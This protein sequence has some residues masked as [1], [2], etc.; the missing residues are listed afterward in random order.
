[1]FFVCQYFFAS[2][3]EKIIFRLAFLQ[4]T[5]YNVHAE[6]LKH[7]R[8]ES[9]DIHEKLRE[10][11]K[12]LDLTML[13]VAQKTGVSEATISRWESGDI[14]NMRR[15]K[16]ISLANALQ[17]HPSFIMGEDEYNEACANNSFYDNIIPLPNMNK[18]PLI[19]TI[20]CG[21]PIL[22][23]ENIEC[24]IDI[25]EDINADFAL[26]CSGNSMIDARIL[27]GDIVYI[28]QQPTVNNGEIAAVL[29]GNEAT[30]KKVYIAENTVTLVA[31]NTAYQPLVYTNEQLNEIRILG[32][33]V[34]FTSR[35]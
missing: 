30:L 28:R 24:E 15:D 26:R 3:F 34:G 10:R 20:A 14:A 1:M 8:G 11:R 22:A 19:G 23:E 7:Q 6:L 9:V 16:I 13:Q 33:A 25:P 12:E 5:C 29:I 2:F 32:K 27:D 21:E 4:E 18:V 31:C 17:V 35:I